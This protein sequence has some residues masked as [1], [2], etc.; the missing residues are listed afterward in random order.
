MKKKKGEGNGDLSN[1]SNEEAGREMG[2]E[3]R[4]STET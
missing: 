1:M 3:R 4:G 2:M